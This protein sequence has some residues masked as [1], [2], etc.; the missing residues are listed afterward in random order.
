MI[1]FNKQEKSRPIIN[2]LSVMV[3]TKRRYILTGNW[4]ILNNVDVLKN[5]KICLLLKFITIFFLF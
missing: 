3:Y 1:M 2:L 5:M 4:F